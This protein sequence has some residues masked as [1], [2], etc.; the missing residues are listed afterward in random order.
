M[1]NKTYLKASLREIRQSKGRFIAITLIIFLGTFLFVGVKATGPI[2]NHSASEYVNS[3]HLADLQV[4][5]T[6]GLTEDDI[7]AAKK[8]GA[9]TEAAYQFYYAANSD[10]V[11]QV[12]SY[13]PS[14]ELNQLLVK[15]G[16]L[17]EKAD[18]IVLDTEAKNYGWQIGDTFTIDDADNLS[19][20]EY[21]IVGFATSPI[22]ISAAE[23]GYAN[24]GSG[25]DNQLSAVQL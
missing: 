11:V 12:T 4:T 6:L 14:Q 19:D 18:E 2:L 13:D 9:H 17:P 7:D 3:Q 23:R 16:R 1:K 22:Y 5:S 8:S 21:T 10:E 24:V 20:K 25:V 15:D